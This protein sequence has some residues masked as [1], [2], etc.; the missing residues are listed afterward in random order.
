LSTTVNGVKFYCDRLYLSKL[1]VN[2]SLFTEPEPSNKFD[3]HA[4]KLLAP[5]HTDPPVKIMLGYVPA[6]VSQIIAALLNLIPLTFKVTAVN[7]GTM[8]VFIDI[9]TPYLREE[10]HA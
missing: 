1:E 2:E 5:S 9:S 8:E 4:V 3:I 10:D 6:K 7:P